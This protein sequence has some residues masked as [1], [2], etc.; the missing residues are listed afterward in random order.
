MVAPS[1]TD[2]FSVSVVI[3]TYNRINL[4]PQ[5]PLD[6]ALESNVKQVEQKREKD[7]GHIF[8]EGVATVIF[9]RAACSNH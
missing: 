6:P 4:L 2:N 7:E 5:A 1:I 3:P 9:A 8:K